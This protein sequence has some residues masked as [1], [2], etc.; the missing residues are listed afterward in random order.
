MSPLKL[1]RCQIVITFSRNHLTLT[2]DRVFNVCALLDDDVIADQRPGQVGARPDDDLVHD[3]AVGQLDLLLDGAVAA[4]DAVL[5]GRL[6]G[7]L[8]VFPNQ[9]FRPDLKN[10]VLFPL[11]LF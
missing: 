9:T 2:N 4:D 10:R 8:G 3:D 7:N 11:K 1:K 5:D 6:L